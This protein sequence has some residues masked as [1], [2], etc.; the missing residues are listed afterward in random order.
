MH[1]VGTLQPL[2]PAVGWIVIKPDGS[3]VLARVEL[4]PPGKR[5]GM[6]AR[7]LALRAC[8]EQGCVCDV[9]IEIEIVDGLD[10]PAAP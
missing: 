7:D 8:R 4:D 5:A 9:D 1:A 3:R 2:A 10:A 6:K